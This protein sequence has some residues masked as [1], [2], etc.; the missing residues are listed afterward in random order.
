MYA[1]L[2]TIQKRKSHS[3]HHT[4]G[5]IIACGLLSMLVAS[6]AKGQN[7][8]LP[9][10]KQQVFNTSSGLCNNNIRVIT[11]DKTG[12]LWVGT[13]N[14]L[15][16]F[17]GQYFT[18][19]FHIPGD[20]NSLGH[21]F[22][23]GILCDAKGKIW[24]LHVLGLSAFDPET[25]QFTN[26]PIQADYPHFSG[27]FM[28]FAA[29]GAG[30]L[31][32]GNQYGLAVFKTSERRY[33]SLSQL[34]GFVSRKDNGFAGIGINGIV[35][36]ENG[37]MWLN[38]FNRLI[39]WNPRNKASLEVNLTAISGENSSLAINYIDTITKN[40]Y[41]GTFNKGLFQYHYNNRQWANFRSEPLL[42][43]T[44]NYDPIRCF[45]PFSNGF[46]TFI[47]ELGI[48]FFNEVT[49]KL[50][51]LQPFP[52]GKD[53]N[54]Q[55]LFIDSTHMW[56]GTNNGLLLFNQEKI[57][58]ENI[59]PANRSHGA[60]NT[61]Q[62]HPNL[63]IIF[64]GNYT[65]P[66]V[67]QM[68]SSGGLKKNL[69]GINGLLRYFFADSKGNEWLSTET[70]IYR[71]STGTAIWQQISLEMLDA[72]MDIHPRNFTED[73]D[74][75][76]WVRIRNAGVCLFNTQK[77]AFEQ[78]HSPPLPKSSIFS[79]LIYLATTNTIW[80]SE[81]KTGLYSL[82]LYTRK[83]QHHPLQLVNTPLT[84]ARI[85]ACKDGT[86]AFPD[87]FNGIGIY[88]PV[89][90]SIRLISQKE[91]LLSNNV[92]SIEA[93]EEGNLWTYASEGISKIMAT[94]NTVV[95][96]QHPSLVKLQ[97]IAC[98]K[99]GKVYVATAEDIFRLNGNLLQPQK[100]I[101]KLLINKVEV[102]GKPVALSAP[103]QLPPGNSD[104]QVT[105]SFINLYADHSATFEYRLG[106]ESNWKSLEANNTI[107][108][109]RLSPG[110]YTLTIRE[111]KEHN[112]ALWQNLYWTIEKPFWQTNWFLVSALLFIGFIVYL[113]TQSRIS[114]ISEKAALQ[115]RV[116]EIEMA[117]LRA[118][119][120]PHFIFNSIN[121]IDAM[122][123]EGDK[124][125]ATTYLNKFAKLLRN[126]LEGSRYSTVALSSDLETL[127]LYL[128]LE[129]MRMD[130]NFS[131]TID[132]SNDV[133][134]ADIRVPS[135]IIQP[136]VENAIL[137]GVRHLTKK[138]GQVLVKV[139]LM[140]DL[141]TYTIS[142]NGLGRAFAKTIQ[143]AQH[144]SFGLEITQKRIEHFNLN[145]SG[146][147]MITDLV[148]EN[149]EPVGTEVKVLLP[150]I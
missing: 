136:Y 54:M 49:G 137:H 113:F 120:N 72:T 140:G 116:A 61:V 46:Q 12:Y 129:C 40:I 10:F 30:N 128:E 32:I 99:D 90:K 35:R 25:Q 57:L 45:Q 2:A 119:M 125:N 47:N 68:P 98:G 150:L 132:V 81:E 138:R 9:T 122:V 107:T 96:F 70:A 66:A 15:S 121:C 111:K 112:P 86:I 39:A 18:N 75:Q 130:E 22:I 51:P 145:N 85:V 44:A 58:L 105:F 87:P 26:Y 11:K 19:F 28:A 103:L 60:F 48:G 74:G 126:V 97:E 92:S 141:L 108:F 142:D 104:I 93:D 27:G 71:K 1:T 84:P 148:N 23:Q 139:E 64:S 149:G 37:Q 144:A 80:L 53:L 55:W 131:W 56:V 123:Q 147:V 42:L 7:V 14:G 65:E 95:N 89:T 106:L 118:Q 135:L 83:W 115:K 77:Q 102:M 63:P 69:K 36:G 34:N 3:F 33:L 59:T 114:A 124:Y 127:R 43:S 4:I 52:L 76:I 50:Y 5:C 101:G 13:A 79:G 62:V 94:D 67:Y 100:A 8:P 17:D 109:S 134:A 146:S 91:G 41:F 20:T 117:A 73:G 16:R 38:T 6:L 110:A 31:W 21:N 24:L 82:N 133:T 143:K 88:H 29:D 78:Y